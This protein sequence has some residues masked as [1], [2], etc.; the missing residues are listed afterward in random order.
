MADCFIYLTNQM[1]NYIIT[2]L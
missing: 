2:L 1:L